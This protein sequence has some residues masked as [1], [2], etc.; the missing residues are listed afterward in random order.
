MFHQKPILIV[1]D[2]AFLALDIAITVE[3]RDGRVVGPVATVAEAI[4]LIDRYPIHGA[5]L[6]CQLADR[7]IEPVA[8]RLYEL[9]IPFVVFS[10]TGLPE[11]IAHLAGKVDV[12]VKP[13]MPHTVIDALQARIIKTV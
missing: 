1:E 4:D 7:D 8:L 3:E 5:V 6:D 13:Q 10:G 11:G 2:N 12:L 9:G